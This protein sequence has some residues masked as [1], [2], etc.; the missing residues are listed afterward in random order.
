MASEEIR[1]VGEAIAALR[2]QFGVTQYE[3]AITTGGSTSLIS[4]LEKGTQDVPLAKLSAI[5]AYFG[6][7]VG[8]LVDCEI[9]KANGPV[10]RLPR[11]APPGRPPAERYL[12][13]EEVA[14]MART[15]A[16]TVR[17]WRMNGKGPKGIKRGRRVLYPLSAVEAWLRGEEASE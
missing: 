6:L 13:T 5:A 4:R 16:S 2:D 1:Q 11:P 14:E 10:R 7:T 15:A 9:H 8:Q 3:L 12:T 17:Y